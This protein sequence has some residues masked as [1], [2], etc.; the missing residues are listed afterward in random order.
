[1]Q[2]ETDRNPLRSLRLAGLLI[3]GILVTLL[4]VSYARTRGQA[5]RLLAQHKWHWERRSGR[6]RFLDSSGWR[7]PFWEFTYESTEAFDAVINW[8]YTLT[9]DPIPPTPTQIPRD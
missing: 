5:E 7:I 9:G 4:F 2:G 1:M 8:R 3:L 6:L